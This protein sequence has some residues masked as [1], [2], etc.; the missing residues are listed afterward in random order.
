MIKLGVQARD[1]VSGFEGVVTARTQFITGCDRYSLTPP[2]KDG[3]FNEAVWF[4]E[5]CIEITGNGILPED[6][7]GNINGGPHN[8]GNPDLNGMRAR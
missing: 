8:D 1:K 5:S 6:V 4:D 2:A 3:K 7:T